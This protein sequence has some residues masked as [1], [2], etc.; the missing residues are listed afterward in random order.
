MMPSPTFGAV[1]RDT[2]AQAGL[3]SGNAGVGCPRRSAWR[4]TIMNTMKHAQSPTI[5]TWIAYQLSYALASMKP[6]LRASD[7]AAAVAGSGNPA[8]V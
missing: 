5:L 4:I 1:E 8:G 7:V 3:C 6:K 2:E